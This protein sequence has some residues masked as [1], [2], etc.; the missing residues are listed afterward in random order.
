MAGDSCARTT[1]ENA[2]LTSTWIREHHSSANRP[3]ILL[4]T[5]PW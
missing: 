1:W 5:D 4:I 3:A 2:S